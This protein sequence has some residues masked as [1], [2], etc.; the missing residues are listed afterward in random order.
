[1]PEAWPMEKRSALK[2]RIDKEADRAAARLGASGVVVIAFFSDGQHMHMLDGGRAP[3]KFADLYQQ[4][5]QLTSVLKASGGEDV[6]L[7]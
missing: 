4:M 2:R 3:M 5:V 6:S 7:Q 1:M